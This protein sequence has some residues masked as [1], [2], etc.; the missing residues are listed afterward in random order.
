VV[1]AVAEG[2]AEGRGLPVKL[3]GPP[4]NPKP[5]LGALRHFA[6]QRLNRLLRAIALLIA[7]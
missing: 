5:P 1:E 4:P 3:M 2:T 6:P 7:L